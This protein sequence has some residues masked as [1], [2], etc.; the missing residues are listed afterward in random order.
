MKNMI[1]WFEIPVKDF[2]RSKKFYEN[3]LACTLETSEMAGF[4]MGMFP[5]YEGRVSGAIVMGEEYE[6]SH[7]G[8]LVY[9]NGNPDLQHCLSRIEDAG[10]KI[11]MPKTQVSPELGF[12]AFFEDCEGN[13]VAL[14]SQH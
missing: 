7:K 14:H 8:S 2:E 5:S 13:K 3:V 1:N 10:G 4:T 12:I 11:L 6:P 9:L